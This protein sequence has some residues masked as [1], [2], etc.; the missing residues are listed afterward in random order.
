VTTAPGTPTGLRYGRMMLGIL[1]RST[2]ND[3]PCMAYEIIA[4]NT[5]MLS[6]VLPMIAPPFSEPSTN[7]RIIIVAKPSTVPAYSAMCG[8]FFAFVS[9]M[10]GR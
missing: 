5:A 6:S 9:D 4:P 1:F 3:R 2:M 8:V 7:H 10:N